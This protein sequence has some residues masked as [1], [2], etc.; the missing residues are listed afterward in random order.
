MK[1]KL[2]I[3]TLVTTW[4]IVAGAVAPA[5]AESANAPDSVLQHPA[6]IEEVLVTA[7]KRVENIQ[8][9]PKSVDV[10]TQE[11]FDKSGVTNISALAAAVPSI[12]STGSGSQNVAA[13]AIRGVKTLASSV[14]VQ[15]KTGVMVDEIAQPTYS[16]LANS[17][18]DVERIEV[19]A[20][21]QSTLSGR[22]AAGGLISITTRA[23]SQ[24]PE[25]DLG[26]VWTD[27]GETRV[28][29][30]GTGPL[31]DNLAAS[32]SSYWDYREGDI[33]SPYENKHIGDT[34]NKGVRGKLLWDATKNLSMTL[35]SYYVESHEETRAVMSGG[36][37]AYMAPNNNSV[38]LL[39]PGPV[40]A[41]FPGWKGKQFDQTVFAPDHGTTNTRDRGVS[42]HVDYDIDA[43]GTLSSLTN[44]QKSNQPTTVDV[45]GSPRDLFSLAGISNAFADS[46]VETHYF[47]QEVRLVSEDMD[48]WTYLAGAIYSDSNLKQPYFRE[49]QR[50]NTDS[51]NEI[52]TA[53]LFGR[54]T[55]SFSENDSLTAG[56]RYQ[57]DKN[58]YDKRYNDDAAPNTY[59]GDSSYGFWGTE[60][61]YK[62]YFTPSVN[63]YVTLARS[64]SGEGYDLENTDAIKSADGL[65]PVK[66]EVVKNIEIGLKSHLFDDRVVF[67]IDGFLAKYD[68][69]QIQTFQPSSNVGQVPV[70]RLM[71]IG[72]VETKGIETTLN[73]QAT[74][75]LRFDVGATYT[76]AVIKDF[77]NA[78]CWAFQT[79]EQGCV[80]STQFPGG[81]QD[82]NGASMPDVPQWK[83]N[84][85]ADYTLFLPSLPFDGNLGAFYRYQSKVH[86]DTF[87][88]PYTQQDAYG[89]LNLY[90]GINTHDDRY[91]VQLFV[92]NVLDKHYYYNITQ[93]NFF[94]QQAEIG[95]VSR[96]AFRYAGIRLNAKFK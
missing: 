60:L 58:S 55:Y 95:N 54:V 10:K 12:S 92:N 83:Y 40:S 81:V 21:P 33:Y 16:S 48:P 32:L 65:K 3:K 70:I 15:S 47:S 91:Q 79:A 17:L 38:L 72:K 62:H 53:A 77:P 88:N 29:A 57:Y 61:S 2:K 28:T 46:D 18:I 66:S 76:R 6:A 84:I 45:V 86:F 64:E 37:W 7:Q 63:A 43:L 11:D 89:I 34:E 31:S 41:A 80:T 82:L 13:P 75:A 14:G 78:P 96:D 74:D 26:T 8:D 59:A 1:A 23:P 71:P 90:A 20:G 69:Y 93:D 42:L 22:N 19:F 85:A 50:S 73:W 39:P 27:D 49:L 35:T 87:D 44:Y 24:I 94:T 52:K 36:G 9:V 68:N 25:L 51:E 4:G 67:N 30:F 5:L 56:L